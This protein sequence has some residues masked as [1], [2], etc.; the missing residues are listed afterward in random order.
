MAIF[1]AAGLCVLAGIASAGHVLL[2][3]GGPELP[4]IRWRKDTGKYSSTDS[5][6]FPAGGPNPVKGTWA[7]VYESHRWA[8][9]GNL[10][11]KIPVPAGKYGIALMFAETWADS[12]R[13]VRQMVVKIN[14][15]P[16]KQAGPKG[17]V[18]VFSRAGG[19]NKPFF[20][21]LGRRASVGGFITVTLERVPGKNNPIRGKNADKLVGNEGLGGTSPGDSGPSKGDC[22]VAKTVTGRMGSDGFVMNVGGPALRKINWG[23]DNTNYIVE[24]DKGHKATAPAPIRVKGTWG[25]VYLRHRWTKAKSLTYKIPVPAGTYKV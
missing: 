12:G 1:R 4:A 17:L 5:G 15:P 2:N 10:E 11:F 16:V 21:R 24:A 6:A 8:K 23:A 19:L 25:P 20:L 13:G 14:G 3:A 9:S 22:P 7:P 18:D